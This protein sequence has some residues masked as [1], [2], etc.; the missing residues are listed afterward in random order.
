MNIRR[1]YGD[2]LK[3][4]HELYILSLSSKQDL[5]AVSY[6]KSGKE[7]PSFN[8]LMD[9]LLLEPELGMDTEW[10]P[11]YGKGHIRQSLLQLSGSSLTV[12]IQIG[13]ARR[14]TQKLCQILESPDIWKYGCGIGED[15]YLL[16]KRFKV[17]IAGLVELEREADIIHKSGKADLPRK[18]CGR[19]R[20]GNP[21]MK[22][23]RGLLHLYNQVM[24]T[25]LPKKD[26]K[27]TMSDW[28]QEQ[29]TTDQIKYAALDSIMSYEI[30]VCLSE[31]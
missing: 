13:N 28:S 5:D 6:D 24:N 27:V 23:P 26:K 17:R 22:G 14:L 9:R 20:K 31:L 1:I 16:G 30:G 7:I 12:L 2:Y 21:V 18:F 25:D 4:D 15:A 10:K 29:L 3:K 8:E 19:D 11:V